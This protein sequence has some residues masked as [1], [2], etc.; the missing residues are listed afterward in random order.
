MAISKRM[1][2]VVT[3]CVWTGISI[4]YYIGMLVR[5]IYDAI[6]QNGSDEDNTMLM[7]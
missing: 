3:L 1:R 2:L 5:M 6:V 7:K 4:L